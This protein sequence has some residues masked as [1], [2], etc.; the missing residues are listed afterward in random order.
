M[1]IYSCHLEYNKLLSIIDCVKDGIL[2][3]DIT[4]DIVIIANVFVHPS[5]SS[6]KRI[7]INNYKATRNAI[8]K[9]MESVPTA[10]DGIKNAENARHPLRNDL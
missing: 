6:R 3:K 1:S 4:E 8:R 10:D 2:P 9:A 5:A 7:F